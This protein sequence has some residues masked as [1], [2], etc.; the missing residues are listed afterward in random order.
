[1]S[2]PSSQRV[3]VL[4][5]RP[6]GVPKE[7]E[8]LVFTNDAVPQPKE[9]ELLIKNLIMS[10][11][12]A[13]RPQ[14]S[15]RTYAEPVPVGGPM[16]AQTLGEV[17]VPSG[18][19][20]VGALV[21]GSGGWQ[22][23]YVAKPAEVQPVALPEG[24]PLTAVLGVLGI[25]GLTAF[26]GLSKVAEPKAGETIL[27]SGAGGATG[28]VVCQLAKN[29]F[30][31]KVYGI[32]GGQE[33]CRFL[34]EDLGLDGAIDYKAEK[35]LNG[36]IKRACPRGVDVYWDN[37]GGDILN[38][39]LRRMRPFGRV[40]MCG[41]I[42]NY[43][44]IG[45]NEGRGPGIPAEVVSS[46]VSSRLLMRGFIVTD[47]AKEIPDASASLARWLQEG[48]LKNKETVVEGLENA[49]T[50]FRGLFEGANTGKLSVAIATR[51]RL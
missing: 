51:S 47:W 25:T 41:T 19:F 28:N 18:G 40:V 43:Q 13:L 8:D 26:F 4:A 36:A 14:M 9:G 49:A 11:D 6:T 1:M 34:L 44:S 5:K 38:A 39:A 23:Y 32:A 33:K 27:V 17:V 12:P 24:V 37:V 7:G 45:S 50:A 46:I 3:V 30:G 42:S 31:C 2:V 21:M 35:D 29:V 10:L 20:Q 16:R 48:K 15:I 22:E